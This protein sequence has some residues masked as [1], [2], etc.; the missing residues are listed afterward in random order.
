MRR[1]LRQ[2]IHDIMGILQHSPIPLTAKE[3]C[4]LYN[5]DLIL[6]STHDIWYILESAM[7]DGKAIV[8]TTGNGHPKYSLMK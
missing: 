8:K 4:N 5:K 2:F 1:N 6:L 7:D 3:I